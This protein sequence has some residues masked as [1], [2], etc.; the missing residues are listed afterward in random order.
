M[1]FAYNPD[2]PSPLYRITGYEKPQDITPP[3]ISLQE[4]GVELEYALL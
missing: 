3:V 1:A 4:G 2:A